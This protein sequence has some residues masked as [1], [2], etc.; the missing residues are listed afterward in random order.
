MKS[1]IRLVHQ[2]I[3]R[4]FKERLSGNKEDEQTADVMIAETERLNRVISP[5]Y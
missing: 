3:C 4:Y 5:A 1:V 2:R